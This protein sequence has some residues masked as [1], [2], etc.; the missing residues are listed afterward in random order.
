MAAYIKY[1]TFL[2]WPSS[3][4]SRIDLLP[5][6][7]TSISWKHEGEDG[8]RGHG[9]IM[10]GREVVAGA[11]QERGCTEVGKARIIGNCG[12]FLFGNE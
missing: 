4:T 11:V 1:L 6:S 3:V 9:G 12:E 5:T 7:A 10:G 8:D 2:Q